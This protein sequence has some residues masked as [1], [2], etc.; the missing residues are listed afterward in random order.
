MKIISTLS[1]ACLIFAILGCGNQ[2]SSPVV[3]EKSEPIAT[4]MPG[5]VSRILDSYDFNNSD[6]KRGLAF[7]L[8]FEV[9]DGSLDG[10]WDAYAV[11]FLWG[12][13]FGIPTNVA[14][15]TDWTG[16][17]SVNG[18]ADIKVIHQI[19]FE[20]DQD[21]LVED[22]N[23]AL[24]GWVSKTNGDFDGLCFIVLIKREVEYFAP[25]YLTF[26][27]EPFDLQLSIDQLRLFRVFYIA[28]NFNAVAVFAHKIWQN[29]CASGI[30]E[31]KWIK[32]DNTGLKGRIE[33]L[34]FNNENIEPTGIFVGQFWTD[35]N[36]DRLLEGSVS[37]YIT[38]Q[39]IAYLKGRWFYDDFRMCPSADCGTG[40]GKFYGRFEFADREGWGYFRGEFGWP[41]DAAGLTL[42]LKGVWKQNCPTISNTDTGN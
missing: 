16:D 26:N 20:A 25:L 23:P 11:T 19:D 22:D 34:W 6:S 36:G 8:P 17:L 4:E 33:G 15:E 39:V 42:P 21:Y 10:E 18:V 7:P 35:E 38:D 13:F 9:I 37:G 5:D 41:V 2:S 24:A 40:H 1:L 30:M 3:S 32:E 12:Q 29:H 27:T 14:I 28:D 31:G